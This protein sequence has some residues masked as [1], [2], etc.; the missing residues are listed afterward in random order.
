MT[1]FEIVMQIMYFDLCPTPLLINSGQNVFFE[2]LSSL[3]F[4]GRTW[5]LF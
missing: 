1:L 3:S 2:G 5:I 4:F